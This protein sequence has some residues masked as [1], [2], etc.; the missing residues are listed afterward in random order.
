[1]CVSDD[2]RL[3]ATREWQGVALWDMS[4]EEPEQLLMIPIPDTAV[5]TVA[6]S[7]DKCLLCVLGSE[8]IRLF[9]LNWRM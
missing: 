5:R 9:S 1:M 8:K 7:A 6:I 2:G 4:E 3:L